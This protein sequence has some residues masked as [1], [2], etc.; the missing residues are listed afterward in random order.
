MSR[1][2][3]LGLRANWRQF[4][5]LVAVN[6]FV[7]GMVGLER[8][9][10]PLLADAEFGIASKAAAVSF[11]STF[12]LAKAV[13]NLLAGHLA[14]VVTRKR[15]LV[16]GW[17]FGLPVPF[18][19]MLAPNWG[20]VVAANLLLGANQ[21]L[22]WSMTVNMKIDL[23]GP[24]QR[25]L[26]LGLNEAAGYLA[27]AAAAFLTGVIAE[28]YG[29][30]P[31]PFY[32]GVGF[33]AA[34]LAISAVLVRDTRPFL[35]I[36]TISHPAA[37]PVPLARTFAE[38]TWRLPRLWGISQTGFF[39]NL[40]DG[41][42]WG[43]FP[44]FFATQG[45]SLGRI[46]ALAAIY[47]LIWGSL[48]ILTGWLSDLTGRKWLIVSGMCLQ[49]FAIWLATLANAFGAWIVAVG[50]VGVGT[51]MVYPTLLAAIGD[52][53]HPEQRSAALGVY[54]FWRDAGA[55]AGALIGGILADAFGFAPAIR[56]VALL[57]LLSGLLAA[58]TLPGRPR[59]F[60]PRRRRR[61]D[62][63]VRA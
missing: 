31:E 12:G 3:V 2:P 21:G 33:A 53:V 20:W 57:T 39:N 7:G 41:V 61:E 43:I 1:V 22:T 4:A 60:S 35:A 56:F 18:I 28:R 40:N 9:I 27:V 63:P 5:L 55:I 62:D 49:A 52:A 19:L 47:P 16:I 14:G 10:L 42:I 26:A 24:R 8:S 13:T 34:G 59:G 17:L 50:L 38:A 32:L 29:L 44:L 51:A 48:Q 54:R 6:A 58:T 11:I 36:E 30:R 23:V 37:A 15:L 46:A 45:M 25:G